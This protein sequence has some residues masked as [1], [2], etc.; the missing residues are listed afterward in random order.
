[1]QHFPN[2]LLISLSFSP[3]MVESRRYEKLTRLKHIILRL[4]PEFFQ[5]L[6]VQINNL[7]QNPSEFLSK[8]P[9]EPNCSCQLP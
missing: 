6:L 8:G 7:Q 9:K 5:I 1:M 2:A 3:G 4:A